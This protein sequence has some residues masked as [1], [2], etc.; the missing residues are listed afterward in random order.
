[1]N[2]NISTSSVTGKGNKDCQ[3]IIK[4]LVRSDGICIV[5]A[6]GAGSARFPLEGAMAVA[7]GIVDFFKSDNRLRSFNDIYNSDE[8]SI[9]KF[10]YDVAIKALCKRAEALRRD[11]VNSGFEISLADVST[12]MMCFL[13]DGEKYIAL[14]I[15]DGL[16]G[17]YVPNKAADVILEPENIRYANQTYYITDD[18]AL[19]HLRVAKGRYESDAAYIIMTDGS[20]ECTYRKLTKEFA[21]IIFKF[22]EIVLKYPR[23]VIG[24]FIFEKMKELFPKVTNDDC[25]LVIITGKPKPV[26]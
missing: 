21:P 24:N 4:T 2:W 9:R 3:D 15:G 13:S 1:M 6:D 10:F 22:C 5:A 12:T 17:R 25:A 19:D 8:N 11:N 23:I 7:K 26:V 20:V 14:N 16:I 18:D